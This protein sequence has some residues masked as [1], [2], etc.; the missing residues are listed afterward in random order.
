MVWSFRKHGCWALLGV[1]YDDRYPY[2][3]FPAHYIAIEK[4]LF[5]FLG[6]VCLIRLGH[7]C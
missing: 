3:V 2:T 4:L 7:G 6:S 1:V 5:L